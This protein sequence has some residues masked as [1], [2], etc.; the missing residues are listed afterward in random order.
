MREEND[1]LNADQTALWA[2]DRKPVAGW[3]IGRFQIVNTYHHQQWAPDVPW[4]RGYGI[5]A[6][7]T[8]TGNPGRCGRDR[9]RALDLRA[10]AGHPPAVD[11]LPDSAGP[12]SVW[13]AAG[14]HCDHGDRR[15]HLRRVHR[16]P[17]I[18]RLSN[19]PCLLARRNHDRL[20][21]SLPAVAD[22]R[23][24]RDRRACNGAT[25]VSRGRSGCQP[26]RI[27]VAASQRTS[28]PFSRRSFGP[29]GT[30]ATSRPI[31]TAPH[32]QRSGHSLVARCCSSSS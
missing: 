12:R 25:W 15:P 16:R 14:G 19:A 3:G 7:E 18:V 10:G 31:G 17:P 20:V 5:V 30:S 24:R 27:L 28:G 22:G 13:Q 8:R 29:T 21:R 23:G 11:S 6:H 2:F 32:G 9:S 4:T 26:A 1:R